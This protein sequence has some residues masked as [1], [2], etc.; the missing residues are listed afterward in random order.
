MGPRGYGRPGGAGGRSSE[1]R[2]LGR[3]GEHWQGGCPATGSLCGEC[4]GGEDSEGITRGECSSLARTKTVNDQR[5]VVTSSGPVL[6]SRTEGV[7]IRSGHL[8]RHTGKT[9]LFWANLLVRLQLQN[10]LKMTCDEPLRPSR[11]S[12]L[13]LGWGQ[14]RLA[15]RLSGNDQPEE[16]DDSYQIK[17]FAGC[18]PK[19]DA[20]RSLS[21]DSES[22]HRQDGH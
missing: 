12:R 14:Q 19:S 8:F 13:T 2:E 20:T 21:G 4:K 17:S 6:P 22:A 9:A 5:R 1:M 11:S 7:G 10:L 18:I 16:G 15:I 3:K